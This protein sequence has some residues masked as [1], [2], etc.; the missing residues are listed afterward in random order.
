MGKDTKPTL[1]TLK[2]TFYSPQMAFTL[3][4][5]TW[6]TNAGYSCTMKGK[7]CTIMSPSNKVVGR[8][9]KICG[10]YCATD[11]TATK[12]EPKSANATSQPLT[13]SQLHCL[14]GYIN[15]N[16]LHTMVKNG[17][18]EGIDL[19]MVPGQNS[20]MFASRQKQL[21]NLFQRRV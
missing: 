10:L 3:I 2:D 15:H 21:E 20:V 19:D 4:S 14:M 6:I 11:T 13:I 8:I 16:D 9:P 5:V 12:T 1:I 7:T 17:I 18:V